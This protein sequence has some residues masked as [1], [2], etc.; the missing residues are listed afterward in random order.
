MVSVKKPT[1][2]RRDQSANQSNG[3]WPE[4]KISV[5]FGWVLPLAEMKM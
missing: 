5:L 2:S 1:H 4:K 3:S